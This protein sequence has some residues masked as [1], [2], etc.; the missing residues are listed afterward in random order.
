M[1]FQT[2]KT[3]I[4]CASLFKSAIEAIHSESSG[5]R[6][7]FS[8]GPE[9]S[10]LL[11]IDFARKCFAAIDWVWRSRSIYEGQVGRQDQLDQKAAG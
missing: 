1:K 10:I 6:S 9:L 11:K 4:P 3:N 7:V 2:V 8:G 5:G